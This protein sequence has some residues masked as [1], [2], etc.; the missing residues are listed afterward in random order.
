MLKIGKNTKMA[1]YVRKA[2]EMSSDRVLSDVYKTFSDYKANA[3]LH[4]VR[5]MNEYGGYGLRIIG[6]NCMTFSVAFVFVDK[7]TGVCNMA[8]ITK[9]YDRYF[10]F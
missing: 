3:M 10:E 1:N 7:E 9:D 2:W 6:H 4:C 5:L 8:Y